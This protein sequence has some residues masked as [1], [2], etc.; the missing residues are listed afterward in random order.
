MT[1][2]NPKSK[3]AGCWV[4]R[5]ASRESSRDVWRDVSR[6]VG[7]LLTKPQDGEEDGE[8]PASAA[9][10]FADEAACRGSQMCCF[11]SDA[12]YTVDFLGPAAQPLFLWDIN[13]DIYYIMAMDKIRMIGI[14]SRF[15]FNAGH[16]CNKMEAADMR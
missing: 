9:S 10:A 8:A 15:N 11:H 6:L 14:L 12:F 13:P 5:D 2:C 7:E 16:L 3:K 4:L 1:N